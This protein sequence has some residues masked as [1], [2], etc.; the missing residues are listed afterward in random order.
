MS[1]CEKGNGKG[2]KGIAEGKGSQNMGARAK[3]F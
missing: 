2:E 3:L 1:M